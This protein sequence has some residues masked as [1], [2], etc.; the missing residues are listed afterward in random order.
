MEFKQLSF[1]KSLEKC[2][3]VAKYDRQEKTSIMKFDKQVT[4]N[5]QTANDQHGLTRRKRKEVVFKFKAISWKS[6]K[7]KHKYIRS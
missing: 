7:S 3:K 6:N 2:P 1:D 4:Q 5:N